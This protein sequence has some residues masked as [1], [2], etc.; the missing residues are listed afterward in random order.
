MGV[1]RSRHQTLHRLSLSIDKDITMSRDLYL[2][3]LGQV[4]L[5]PIKSTGII[6][7]LHPH[8]A[9]LHSTV[10]VKKHG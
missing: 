7:L 1:N 3:P 6:V 9:G 4:F 2:V 10:P 5:C 8:L